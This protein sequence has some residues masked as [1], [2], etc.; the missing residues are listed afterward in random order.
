[1]LLSRAFVHSDSAVV[2]SGAYRE[3]AIG[4]VLLL[5]SELLWHVRH[6]IIAC[7]VVMFKSLVNLAIVVGQDSVKSA[8]QPVDSVG[9]I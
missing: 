2:V 7:V 5:G 9:L 3:Q 1:M 6:H 4:D 8:F